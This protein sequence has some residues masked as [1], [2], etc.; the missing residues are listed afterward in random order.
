MS[1]RLL[2][3]II[4]LNKPSADYGQGEVN[5]DYRYTEGNIDCYINNFIR[6]EL[7][8]FKR[9]Q[10]QEN[11]EFSFLLQNKLGVGNNSYYVAY[12]GAI[13]SA[14]R[15]TSLDF[16]FDKEKQPAPDRGKPDHRKDIFDELMPVMLHEENCK[17][18][19]LFPYNITQSHWITG[20]I[21]LTKKND[22]ISVSI[23]NA[24]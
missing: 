6:Y 19:I 2:P 3:N 9:E 1:K 13:D 24:H 16:F 12:S 17:A 8:G 22:N 7:G 5:P 10:G 18:R 11:T 21:L 23:F 20:E 4:E 15:G 14:S